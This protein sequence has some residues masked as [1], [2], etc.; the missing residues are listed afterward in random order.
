MPQGPAA[1]ATQLEE[2]LVRAQV[3]WVGWVHMGD[4]KT[5]Q[6]QRRT[7]PQNGDV[8]GVTGAGRKHCRQLGTDPSGGLRMMLL[9]SREG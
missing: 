4:L 8:L 9:V 2:I 3:T 5:G 6:I 7:G 1:A